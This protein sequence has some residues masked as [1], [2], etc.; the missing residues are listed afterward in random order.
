MTLDKLEL[1]KK[2][3][4]HSIFNSKFDYATTH[5]IHIMDKREVLYTINKEIEQLKININQ[6][7][8]L[9]GD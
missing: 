6:D 9:L 8:I 1:T 7:I 3:I 4:E 5:N 2:V